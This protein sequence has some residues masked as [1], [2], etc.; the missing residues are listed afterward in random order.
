M[1]FP[2]VAEV[3]ATAA[4]YS[5]LVTDCGELI[6]DAFAKPLTEDEVLAGLAKIKE[7][8]AAIAADVWATV[9]S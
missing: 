3:I 4:K 2:A 1:T 9:K 8:E 7:R 6:R 5:G